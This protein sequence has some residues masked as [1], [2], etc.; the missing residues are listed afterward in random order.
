MKA[1]YRPLPGENGPYDLNA[2]N[3]EELHGA[4]RY[5]CGNNNFRNAAL[6]FKLI[7]RSP[8]G[9]HSHIYLKVYTS[10]NFREKITPCTALD[11]SQ[12]IIDPATAL[13]IVGLCNVG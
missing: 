1:V 6:G 3:F 4:L 7:C 9:C 13:R 10:L 2:A 11:Y 12:M 5:R 8:E